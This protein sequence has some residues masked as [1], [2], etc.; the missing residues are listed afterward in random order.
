M[1]MDPDGKNQRHF[2]RGLRNAVGMRWIDNQL[3]VTNMGADHL[4]L[5][6]PADTMGVIKE[7]TNYGWPY[8]YQAGSAVYIDQKYNPRG[9]KF[10]CKQSPALRIPFTAHAAP[11][12]LEYFDNSNGAELRSSF[13]VAL[14]GSTDKRIAHGYSVVKVADGSSTPQNFITGFLEKGV[15]H[16]RP[17]DIF[18]FGKDA[19]LLT[20]DKSG[21]IYYVHKTSNAAQ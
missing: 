11:L 6:K 2:A 5:Q 20:D 4:G 19:F 7:G 16:G 9:S 14:H 21:V 12:G 17:C 13:L 15:V 8:C 18:S 1:E 10:D 3:V